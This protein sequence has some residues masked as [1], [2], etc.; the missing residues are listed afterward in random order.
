MQNGSEAQQTANNI[1][2]NKKI[3]LGIRVNK[4]VKSNN[5]KHHEEDHAKD[6]HREVE[7]EQMATP[8]K[9]G[10]GSHVY[11]EW[12]RESHSLNRI[13]K[14]IQTTAYRAAR[15]VQVSKEMDR[16]WWDR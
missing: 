11:W 14:Q 4:L 15:E 10:T 13:K 5:W 3:K 8:D 7:H 6:L 12:G 9:K 2:S 16:C 1:C